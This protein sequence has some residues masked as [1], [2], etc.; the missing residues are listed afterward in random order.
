MSKNIHDTKRLLYSIKSTLPNFVQQLTK[1]LEQPVTFEW[2]FGSCLF[3]IL[4][5]WLSTK[6][7]P[8]MYPTQSSMFIAAALYAAL[9]I[10]LT[11]LRSVLY[12]KF[13]EKVAIVMIEQLQLIN[14]KNN[15]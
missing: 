6:I 11:G 15:K 13:M 4:A 2:S 1:V 10:L 5:V 14:K 3:P 12:R 8:E 9:C 7:W